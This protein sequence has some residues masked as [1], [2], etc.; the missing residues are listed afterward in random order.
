VSA[1]DID[2][3]RDRMLEDSV[4]VRLSLYP[5]VQNS[6]IETVREIQIDPQPFLPLI[7]SLSFTSQRN[8]WF[9]NL[10]TVSIPPNIQNFL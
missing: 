5:N 8:G 2:C 6:N 7:P 4:S 10:S 1:V 3:D 9:V